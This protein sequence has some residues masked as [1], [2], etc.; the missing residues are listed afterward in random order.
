[1]LNTILLMFAFVLFIIGSFWNP[2][3]V[4]LVAVGLACWVL[5]ELLPLVN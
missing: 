5:S 3:K 2:P 4:N 1:M